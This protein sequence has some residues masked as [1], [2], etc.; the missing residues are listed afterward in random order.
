M[1]KSGLDPGT[2]D[3]YTKEK[4][5]D[6]CTATRHTIKKPLIRRKIK[7]MMG[8]SPPHETGQ[9]KEEKRHLNLILSRK[10]S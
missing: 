6:T 3:R 2:K 7:K 8:T 10:R 1:H 4:S 5:P 9:R